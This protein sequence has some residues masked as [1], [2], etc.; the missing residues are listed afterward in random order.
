MFVCSCFCLFVLALFVFSFGQLTVGFF[1]LWC[2][3]CVFFFWSVLGLFA[4]LLDV[5]VLSCGCWETV[6]MF[7]YF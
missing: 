3:V 1:L 2:V 6:L 5:V 7:L 4:S